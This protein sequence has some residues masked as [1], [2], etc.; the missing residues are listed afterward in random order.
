M[1]RKD[2]VSKRIKKK[3]KRE[4]AVNIGCS[5]CLHPWYNMVYS[6]YGQE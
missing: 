6:K 5:P 1:T 4:V 2:D 3:R